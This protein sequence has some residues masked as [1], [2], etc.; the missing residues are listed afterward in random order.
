MSKI[1]PYT[2]SIKLKL[3]LLD[4]IKLRIGGIKY[5]A[6]KNKISMD[7]QLESLGGLWEKVK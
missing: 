1:G 2:I 7:E 3:S 6:N 5:K 4:V